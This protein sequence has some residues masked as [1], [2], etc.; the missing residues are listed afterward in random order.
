M[1][2]RDI[3]PTLHVA[4]AQMNS[5]LADVRHNIDTHIAYIREAE[6]EGAQLLLFPELSLTGYQLKS[7][8]RDVAMSRLD[9][10][11]LELASISPDM[12]V[13]VGFVEYASPGEYYNAM[14]WL[15]NGTVEAVHRKVNLPT[16]GGLEEGKWYHA[17][18]STTQVSV[19]EGW[20][21]SVL[22]CADLWNPPLVHCALQHKPEMLLASINSASDIVSDDFSN[23]KNWLIN[24]MFYAVHYGTPVLMANRYGSEGDAWF[25]GGSCILSP[26]GKVLAQAEDKECLITASLALAD[27]DKARFELPTMRDSNPDLIRSLLAEHKE[28]KAGK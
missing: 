3:S 14:A 11:L 27:I 25:W 4:V 17:G 6:R 28:G 10:R 22:I 19:T 13:V 5:R 20:A 16:Y 18:R 2:P 8:V 12:S 7:G 24:L 9:P 15:K 26:S 21:A 1:S 23:E